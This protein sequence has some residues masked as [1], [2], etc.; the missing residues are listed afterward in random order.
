M[1]VS[2]DASL[3][4]PQP[5]TRS[6]RVRFCLTHEA[7]NNRGVSTRHAR[8]KLRGLGAAEK[9]K[10]EPNTRPDPGLEVEDG[11]CDANAAAHQVG[12]PR[13]PHKAPPPPYAGAGLGGLGLPV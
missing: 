7:Q 12:T 3:R 9:V 10:P 6:A 8:S 13:V 5:H 4:L 11:F 1:L 2:N